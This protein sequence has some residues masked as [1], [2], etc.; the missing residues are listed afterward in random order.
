LTNSSVLHG[1]SHEQQQLPLR[2][3][4]AITIHKSQ[5]LTL[6]KAWIDLGA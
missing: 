4:W 6:D 2:L 3:S 5:G 1:S